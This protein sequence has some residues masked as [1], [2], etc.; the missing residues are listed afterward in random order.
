MSRKYKALLVTSK[1]DGLEVQAENAN[2]MI[3]MGGLCFNIKKLINPL[4]LV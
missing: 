3:R 4:N 2:C 1:E